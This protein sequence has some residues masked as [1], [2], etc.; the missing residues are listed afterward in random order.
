MKRVLLLWYFEED[1]FGDTL[2]YRTTRDFLADHGIETV[3]Y[4][5]GQPCME[6]F[7][8]ANKTDFL[9]FAGGGIIESGVPNVIRHFKEDH[10]MLS[11]PYGV[12][13]LGVSDWD[14][15]LFKE[16]ITFWIE[17]ASFF[18]VRDEYSQKRLVD[19]T[20]LDS[21][22]CSADCVFHNRE[23]LK[24]GSH[25]GNRVGINL[26]NLPFKNRTGDFDTEV[27]R[28]VYRECEVTCVIP[29]ASEEQ[30]SKFV[31]VDNVELL[32]RY[33]HMD[34]S[35]RI[36]AIINELR[37]CEFVIAMRYHVILVA[38]TLG[39]LPIPV[40][41]HEKVR[42]L[43]DSLGLSELS[44][45]IS[46]IDEIP[47]KLRKAKVNKDLYLARCSKN[48]EQ[49][50]KKSDSMYQSIDNYIKTFKERTQK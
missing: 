30:W 44:V 34:R 41:Y 40:I 33:R 43:V 17:N 38:A 6:I 36:E 7:A 47:D 42:S 46:E 3:P 20:G 24:Y 11:V 26:R 1:N 37:S 49:L 2:L 8:E 14:Y 31:K 39:I 18:Y 4:E 32:H 10:N 29:D 19:L 5:V 27:L 9:L 25:I 35:E 45:E 22:L 15:S 13:G 50:R 28:D 12:I 23:I 21:V 48:I 16:Q